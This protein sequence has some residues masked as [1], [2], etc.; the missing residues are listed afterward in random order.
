MNAL[1]ASSV[2]SAAGEAG[3]ASAG[4]RVKRAPDGK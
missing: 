1:V 4:A 2:F 3:E